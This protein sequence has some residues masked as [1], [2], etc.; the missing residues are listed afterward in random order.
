MLIR[1]VKH[2]LIVVLAAS[3]TAC[4]GLSAG[5]LF[6]HYTQQNTVVYQAVKT[7]QYEKAQAALPQA[8]DVVAGDIL[9]NFERG[10]VEFLNQSYPQSKSA[11]EVS[12]KAVRVQQDKALIS[13]TDTATSVGALAVNDNITEY[14]P[15]DYEL[16]YLHLYL[17]LNYI[18]KNDLE[19][20]LVEVRRANQVQQRARQARE[21][22]LR[23][24]EAEMKQKGLSPNLGSV[25]SRYP[26]AG[27]QLKAIQNGYLLFLSGL[28]YEA[29]NDLNGAYIDYTRALAVAP[30]NEAVIDAVIRVAKRSSRNQ[31]LAKLKKQYG[32]RPGVKAGEGRVILFEEQGVVSAMQ[33]WNLTL[34]VYDS[35]GNTALYTVALPYYVPAVTPK[36]SNIMLD[37]KPLKSD[38]LVDTNLMAQQQLTENM[39]TILL[40]QALRVYAKDQI[41]KSTAKDDDVGN[42]IFNV[43][44]TLTEQPDTRSWQTL[45]GVVNG[46]SQIVK[47]GSHKMTLDGQ[48]YTFDVRDRQTTLVWVS[49]Q[50]G[51]ATIWHKQL[52]RM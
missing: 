18:Q 8:E 21:K 31:D 13:I 25:L 44:N 35:Q 52:G 2:A 51:N 16:G 1:S 41:R 49:R 9:D 30:D 36:F 20:A 48:D 43:W 40:R 42:L 24:A 39:P 6:S 11:L 23:S 37:G 47:A 29:S 46:A 34:P 45:P 4:A 10:R 33:S 19:G 28:M 15:P 32:D 38:E 5:N 26:D 14:V 27:N 50:G 7:G 12:D 17:G 3:L 22:D